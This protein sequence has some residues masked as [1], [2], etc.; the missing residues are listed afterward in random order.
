MQL[1]RLCLDMET[2]ESRP[3]LAPMSDIAETVHLLFDAVWY[4]MANSDVAPDDATILHYIREGRR[5]LRSQHPLFSTAY[6]LRIHAALQGTIR[7]PLVHFVTRGWTDG[8]N[9]YPLFDDEFY[10][11]QL[12]ALDGLDPLTH[13]V[14]N[15][16]RQDLK[17]IPSFDPGDYVEHC[18]EQRNADVEP[19][20]HFLTN[21]VQR[22]LRGSWNGEFGLTQLEFDRIQLLESEFDNIGSP[23]GDDAAVPI[24]HTESGSNPCKSEALQSHVPRPDVLAPQE[25]QVAAPNTQ[26]ETPDHQSPVECDGSFDEELY[27]LCNPDVAQAIERGAV[28]SGWAH[29]LSSGKSEGRDENPT[30][31]KDNL[32]GITPVRSNPDY[33]VVTRNFDAVE[34]SLIY[35][36]IARA[37]GFDQERCRQHW[38]AAGRHEGRYGPGVRLFAEREASIEKVLQKPFGMN[39]YGPFAAI[40]GLGAA[41]RNLLAAIRKS[42]V[43]YDLH[44]FDVSRGVPRITRSERERYG[45]YRINLI[46]ANADQ[47]ENLVR[48]YPPRYFDNYYN[49]TQWAWELA[50]F[51]PDWYACFGAVDEV[52]AYSSFIVESISAIAPVPVVKVPI[53]ILMPPISAT[54]RDDARR[55][56]AIPRDK[57]VFLTVFDV[58]STSARKNPRS[59]INAFRA[60]FSQ[61]EE[62]F[63]VVKLHSPGYVE[64]DLLRALRKELSDIPNAA[65]I[66]ARLSE[67]EM[68]MLRAASDCL[69]SAHR[70]EGYGLNIAEFMALGKAVVATNYSGNTEFFSESTGYAVDYSLAEIEKQ[71]GPYL[72]GYVWAEP[73]FDSLVEQMKLAFAEHGRSTRCET[74]VVRA[75]EF[76][77]QAIGQLIRARLVELELDADGDGDGI[78]PKFARYLGASRDVGAPAVCRRISYETRDELAKLKYRPRL[79]V[80]VPVYNVPP[81]YLRQCIDSVRSQNYPFWELCLCDDGSTIPETIEALESFRGSDP[82]IRIRRLA[83]N[84]GISDASNAAAEIATG[85]FLILL[86]NDDVILP[87]ALMEVARA[88]NKDPFLDCI[89][90]DEEKIDENGNL[91]D[92]FLK[93]DW[94]PEHLESVMYVLHMLVVRK[95]LFFELGGFRSDYDGAQDYD[96]MLRISRETERIHHIQKVVYQ[97]RAIP[98]SAAAVVDAKP[99]ALESGLRALTEH[100][101]IKY[102]TRARVEKGLLPGTFRLR[103]PLRPDVA[104]TLLI[105]TNNG[106]VDLPGRGRIRLIDNFVDSIL[107]HTSYPEY[108]IVVVDNSRLSIEQRE[109][110]ESLGVRVENFTGPVVPFNYSAKANFSVRCARTE[111]IVILNDDMEVKDDGWLT[112]LMELAEDENIGGVGA[113]LLHADG[114]IQHVGMVLGVNSGAAH[115]Y[116]GFPGDF[117]GYNG[118]THLIRNYSAVTGACFATRKSVIALAGGFD[119][120]LAVDFNDTDLCLRILEC[121]YRIAYTP[122]ALL[123]HFESVSATRESQNPAEVEL[124]ASRWRKYIDNDPYYNIDLSKKRIDYALRTDG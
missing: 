70:S 10:L 1:N 24:T 30:I 56:F 85:Q 71:A 22:R 52:W 99:Y 62:A 98:G 95:R 54:S 33:D 94:S 109:R 88:L 114:T 58:G 75:M 27:L 97:W 51:R 92:H 108:E 14:A 8:F 90:T 29:W 9:P 111:H 64:R 16:W 48:M 36:D 11:P 53:P 107:A 32:Y 38:I 47:I 44:A 55:R 93:P 113:K 82:R 118:F 39:I 25:N 121:G 86:D 104:V 78:P 73:N 76:S 77:P 69:V 116:H 102:G 103:R 67:Q 50:A 89:Y 7:D 60:A 42:G 57:F 46:L 72:P 110:F 87:D 49:I 40:S 83:V 80:V 18:E 3:A 100:A 105:L 106:E 4:R 79:S 74:G 12:P 91:I 124:F 119:E 23:D 45:K 112:A 84:K 2:T 34:Y 28:Q 61:V 19:L 123:Y 26:T 21:R 81:S 41:A 101:R 6:Y 5:Q 65:L 37:L 59:V 120:K 31:C 115:P 122:Y 68:E 63:L 96:L 20:A 35:D 43:P 17:A 15:G 117:V 13:Y 66:A